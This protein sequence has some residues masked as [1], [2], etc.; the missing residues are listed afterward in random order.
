VKPNNA[1]E[2]TAFKSERVGLY[3]TFR[4]P[5]KQTVGYRLLLL[6]RRGLKEEEEERLFNWMAQGGRKESGR[7]TTRKAAKETKAKEEPAT[8]AT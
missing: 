3:N 5:K 2:Q 1:R 6:I 4:G 7:V 8:R